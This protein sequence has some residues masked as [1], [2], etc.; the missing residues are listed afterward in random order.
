M[1]KLDRVNTSAAPAAIGPYSQAIIANGL[2]Y[3]AGQ[4]PLDPASMELVGGD[5]AAAQTE[6]VMR[7]LRAILEAAGASLDSVVKTTVFLADM[8]D[9]GAMNDVY[10]RHFGE[11]RPARSTVQAARLPKD[12]RVEIEA[13]AVVS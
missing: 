4:I 8:N 3:T 1:P 9:F 5:D 10:G 2:A 7:N 11:H 13:I 6:Q 12:V